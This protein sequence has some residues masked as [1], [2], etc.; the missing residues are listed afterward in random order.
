VDFIGDNRSRCNIPEYLDFFSYPNQSIPA[1]QPFKATLLSP[2]LASAHTRIY[3][4]VHAL[5]ST[6]EDE[7]HEKLSTYG[8][9]TS[10]AVKSEGILAMESCNITK[11]KHGFEA[12]IQGFVSLL[13]S[14]SMGGEAA[15]FNIG[16]GIQVARTMRLAIRALLERNRRRTVLA[17]GA[18]D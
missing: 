9:W 17:Q 2:L 8:T 11:R 15:E 13:V 6:N 10:G 4:F 5:M 12:P 7:I 18:A 3:T 14:I 16:V 1:D